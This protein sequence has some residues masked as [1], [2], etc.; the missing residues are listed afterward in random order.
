MA[1][2]V[3]RKPP[4]HRGRTDP[5]ESAC[6]GGA[7]VFLHVNLFTLLATSRNRALMDLPGRADSLD[8]RC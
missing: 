8:C 1:Y 7:P 5:D 2:L 6:W 3:A 4:W